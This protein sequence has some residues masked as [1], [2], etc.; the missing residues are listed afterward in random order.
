MR[1][2]DTTK[3]KLA[4]PT[5]LLRST[6]GLLNLN[7]RFFLWLETAAKDGTVREESETED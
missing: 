6:R 5:E 4:K 2:S 1:N 3:H 7:T